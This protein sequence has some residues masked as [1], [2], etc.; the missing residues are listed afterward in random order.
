MSTHQQPPLRPP[1]EEAKISPA[2]NERD[3]KNIQIKKENAGKVRLKEGK[4]SYSSE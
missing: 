3:F 4:Q 1:I 2:K